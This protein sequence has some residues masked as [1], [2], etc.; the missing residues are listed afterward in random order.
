MNSHKIFC[1]C[2]N[3]HHLENLKKLKYIP[4]GLGKQN[5]DTEW[6][7]DNTGDNIS[8]KN[9][10]YGEY[11][12]YYWV[13]KN[14]LNDYPDNQWLG[15]CGYRY[16]WSQKST[17]SSE[18]INRIINKENFQDYVLKTIPPEWN[19]CDVIIGEEMII[20]NWKF[21]KIIKHAPK[22][23]LMN[24]KFFFKKNQNI[25]LHFDVFHGE[26]IIDKAISYLDKNEKKD[27]VK[28]INQKHSFNR[29]NLFFCKS[30]KLMNDYFKSV[31]TWL[32]KCESE[33]GFELEGY[34]S[35]RIYAFLAERY[36]SF[37]FQKYSKYKTWPIF[38][39]DTNI[40]RIKI[41]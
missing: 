4:V 37:W 21:S 35:K 32:E 10:F 40:N 19:D 20:N 26:G 17:T 29:E 24:P 12:F 18:E 8:S 11:T 16:H 36:L 13:W 38:F 33:F 23:F 14:F 1:M 31:F 25:K 22:K 15:F 9:S 3:S 41:K 6:V 30:K 34:S 2:L 5:Y 28:F 39:Y 7:R 27:F